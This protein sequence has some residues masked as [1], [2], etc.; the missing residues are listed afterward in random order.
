MTGQI[1]GGSVPLTAI[2]YQMAIMVAIFVARYFSSMMTML[3][4]VPKAFDD[5][6]ILNL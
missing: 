6:D 2:K 3:L 4:T 1:L 5:Y